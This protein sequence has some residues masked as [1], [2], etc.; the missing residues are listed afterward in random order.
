MRHRPHACFWDRPAAQRIKGYETRTGLERQAVGLCCDQLCRA[1]DAT[2]GC[3]TEGTCGARGSESVLIGC[4]ALTKYL[5]L[6]GPVFA[7]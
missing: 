1:L 3:E 2:D 5:A 7:D 6:S 4:E